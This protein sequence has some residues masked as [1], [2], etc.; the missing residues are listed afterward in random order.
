MNITYNLTFT[1]YIIDELVY[2]KGILFGVKFEL[3]FVNRNEGVIYMNKS[4]FYSVLETDRNSSQDEIKK[5][6]RKLAMKYHPDKNPDNPEAMKKMKEINEAY[7][8]LSDTKKKQLY[9]TYGHQGLEGYS[10][11]D[12]FS[13][14]DFDSILKGFGLGDLFGSRE[15]FFSGFSSRSRNRSNNVGHGADLRYDLEIDIND[16][17]DGLDKQIKISYKDSCL[18]CNSTGAE[19]GAVDSCSYCDGAGQVIAEQRS[20]F[21]VMRQVTPCL[22]C[23][24]KGVQVK[25]R[26]KKCDGLGKVD[27]DKKINI[28]I[29]P[30]AD[31]GYTLKMEGEGGA[32]SSR[33]GDL[34]IV[35]SVK[36]DIHFF[37]KG[38]DIYTEEEVDSIVAIT[39]ASIDIKGLRGSLSMNL[40]K[41]SQHGD[42]VIIEGS[43]LPEVGS[44]I[45]GRH[46]VI[47]KLITPTGL[48]K[49]QL[50]L[51]E[52]FNNI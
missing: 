45:L 3:N 12:I 11:E 19:N 28:S 49:K 16:V 42:K 44:S 48:N 27:V 14:V 34:Y 18:E 47:L 10:Q 17:V 30:G 46:I 2:R 40:P 52:Q 5:A 36:E 32:G 25:D 22:H 29:P 33:F 24:G 43:G 20:G 4:D 21:T 9:D 51:L 8:V 31:D 1:K 37:R 39:G 38:T 15:G 26:C 41:G 13:N 35:I 23:A 50:E 7:A 6:Y